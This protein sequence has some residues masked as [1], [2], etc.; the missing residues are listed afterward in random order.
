MVEIL[1]LNRMHSFAQ[2]FLAYQF[3]GGVG[4]VVVDHRPTAD[5]QDAAVIR[6]Q[7]EGI[8]AV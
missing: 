5:F 8:D 3:P 6:Q 7:D 4:T 2:G 1:Y